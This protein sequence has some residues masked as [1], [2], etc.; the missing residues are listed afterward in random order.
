M[1]SE[2]GTLSQECFILSFQKVFLENRKSFLESELFFP[3]QRPVARSLVMPITL[4]EFE[5]YLHCKWLCQTE[6][7]ARSC[8]PVVGDKSLRAAKLWACAA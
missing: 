4:T 2:G 5:G 3:W 7:C 6:A 1:R 8:A